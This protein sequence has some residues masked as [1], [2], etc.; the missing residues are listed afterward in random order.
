[1]NNKQN[2][3]LV[4]AGGFLYYGLLVEDNGMEVSIVNA[5]M[6]GGF[7]GGKGLPGVARGAN[8]AKVI[9]DRFL[10]DDVLKFPKASCYGVLPSIDLYSFK[11]TTLR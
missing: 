11:G 4:I 2:V 5:S 3:I 1:M 8:E 9:L 10:P 6:F 7:T